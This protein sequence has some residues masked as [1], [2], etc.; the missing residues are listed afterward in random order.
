MS[1]KTKHQVRS[2]VKMAEKPVNKN[3]SGMLLAISALVLGGIAIFFLAKERNTRS[4]VNR[5]AAAHQTVNTAVRAQ[6]PELVDLDHEFVSVK[7][8]PAVSPQ[9]LRASA[10][11]ILE[12]EGD[13]FLSTQDDKEIFALLKEY[14]QGTRRIQWVFYSE[15]IGGTGRM[16][17]DCVNDRY[18][19]AAPS[20]GSTEFVALGF[21]HEMKHASDCLKYIQK[22]NIQDRTQMKGFYNSDLEG[23]EETAY[24]AQA[25]LYAV[26]YKRGRLPKQVSAET[27]MN[28]SGVM[29]QTIEVW[30]AIYRNN[31]REW[32]RRTMKAGI[33]GNVGPDFIKEVGPVVK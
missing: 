5:P 28:D 22:N 32:Y 20:Q 7:N 11:V 17:Y 8:L 9:Q 27:G 30:G 31:F 10:D 1:K 6:V 2:A 4:V 24:A 21:Y 23:F 13:P 16:A 3:W 26:L 29:Q 15:P 19:V 18:A 12:F 25:R 33:E 14:V